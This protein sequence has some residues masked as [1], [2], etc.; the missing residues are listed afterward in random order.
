MKKHLLFLFCFAVFAAMTSLKAFAGGGCNNNGIKDNGETGIDCG[1]G[2]CSACPPSCVDGIQNQTETAI[3]CG[4]SCPMACPACQT[5]CNLVSNCSFENNYNSASPTV[6]GSGCPCWQTTGMGSY[7][8][9]PGD[10]EAIDATSNYSNSAGWQ[11]GNRATPDIFSTCGGSGCVAYGPNNFIGKQTAHSGNAYG[12]FTTNSNGYVPAW[13][14]YLQI[15][16]SSPLSAGECVTVSFYVSY[17]DNCSL[18]AAV[19]VGAYLSATPPAANAC[20]TIPNCGQIPV[21]PQVSSGT[22]IS[23]KSAWTLI[24]QVYCAT[25]GETY[26]TIGYF[27]N[28]EIAN[29]EA[30]YYVDDVS[31]LPS[32]CFPLPLEL[33]TFKAE[34]K[35]NS[36]ITHW[37]TNSEINNDYFTVER[38]VDAQNFAAVGTVKGAGNSNLENSYQFTDAAPSP[39][40]DIYYYRLRQTDFD[41]KFAYIGLTEVKSTPIAVSIYP[42]PSTDGKISVAI[43]AEY[44]G[45]EITLKIFNAVGKEIYRSA[46]TGTETNIDLSAQPRGVYFIYINTGDNVIIR[47]VMM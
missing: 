26:I 16:L 45:E 29:S 36:V 7:T 38:S 3:D 33:K 22:A 25:G 15:K 11:A 43:P 47:R 39:K 10:F 35:N 4:G 5:T 17:A 14:E 13:R 2:G 12:G 6:S 27:G 46:L 42:N 21:T 1:G 37:V 19:E 23:D 30:Y 18:G 34:Y 24:S 44:S 20:S 9:G 28:A 41:G 40:S 31:V 32:S 8:S